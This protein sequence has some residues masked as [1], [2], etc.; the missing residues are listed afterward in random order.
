M[1]KSP[2]A[3]I[4]EQAKG[5]QAAAQCSAHRPS[6]SLPLVALSARTTHRRRGAQA[7][8]RR[9]RTHAPSA[10]KADL[11]ASGSGESATTHGARRAAVWRSSCARCSAAQQNDGAREA[12][13]SGGAPR[14]RVR[15]PSSFAS[16]GN[17]EDQ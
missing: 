3:K 9:R 15:F 11:P 10:A 16:V 17:R 7:W 8:Q 13:R 4:H 12:R 5:R 14:M 1:C 6:L 2:Q